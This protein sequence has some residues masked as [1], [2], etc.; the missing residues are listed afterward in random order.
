MERGL[1]AAALLRRPV[2][3]RDIRLGTVVE[4]LFDREVSRILGLDVLCGDRNRRFLSLAACEVEGSL[5]RVESA[6][7]LVAEELE[8]YRSRGRALTAL[9]NWK[10]I[11][12]A[13]EGR[14]VSRDALRPAV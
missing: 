3:F 5:V 1:R 9:A 8:F 10:T 6:F 12:V 7:V 13:P 14:V 2:V 11:V 4:V